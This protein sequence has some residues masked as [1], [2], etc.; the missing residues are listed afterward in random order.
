MFFEKGVP[1]APPIFNQSTPNFNC[2]FLIT[3]SSELRKVFL[4]PS[5]FNDFMTDFLPIFL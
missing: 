5:K 4:N 3:F 2:S 1:L